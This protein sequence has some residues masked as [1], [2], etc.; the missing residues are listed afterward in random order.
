MNNILPELIALSS[1][2]NNDD[3]CEFSGSYSNLFYLLN[4]TYVN[5]FK[6]FFKNLKIYKELLNYA[7]IKNKRLYL[8]SGTCIRFCKLKFVNNTKLKKG[9]IFISSTNSTIYSDTSFEYIS[10]YSI[11]SIYDFFKL[12]P[13]Y[14]IEFLFE[15]EKEIKMQYKLYLKHLK[16]M[17]KNKDKLKNKVNNLKKNIYNSMKENTFFLDNKMSKSEMNLFFD[18]LIS[19]NVEVLFPAIVNFINKQDDFPHMDLNNIKK[20]SVCFEENDPYS[21]RLT[22]SDKKQISIVSSIDSLLN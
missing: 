11:S 12:F 6:D 16:T 5:F 9:N 2:N 7:T 10:S 1:F 19:D 15:N 22:F 4:K 20:Y 14:S 13:D 3:D 18:N 8:N 21:F 17:E